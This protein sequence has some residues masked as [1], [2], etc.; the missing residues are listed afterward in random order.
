MNELE[1]FHDAT[2]LGC[3][4]DWASAEVTIRLRLSTGEEALRCSGIRSFSI[5][6]KEEWGPSVSVNSVKV[7]PESNYKRLVVEIQSGDQLVCI[8]QEVIKE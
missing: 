1:R 5:D 4:L 3:E 6:R 2:F 7:T 8:C